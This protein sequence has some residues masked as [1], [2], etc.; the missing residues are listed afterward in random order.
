M[1][2]PTRETGNNGIPMIQ[3][4]PLSAEGVGTGPDCYISCLRGEE[5]GEAGEQGGGCHSA[6]ANFYSLE[7]Y[8]RSRAEVTPT[9]GLSVG[10]RAGEAA[11]T[12]WV[13]CR[14]WHHVGCSLRSMLGGGCSEFTWHF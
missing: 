14:V 11:G 7:L 3:A 5:L 8:K 4:L 9:C 6:T 2:P 10:G 12:S 13:Y 1:S